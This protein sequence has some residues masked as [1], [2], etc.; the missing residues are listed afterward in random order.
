MKVRRTVLVMLPVLLAAGLMFPCTGRGL[1]YELNIDEDQHILVARLIINRLDLSAMVERPHYPDFFALVLAGVFAPFALGSVALGKV[2]GYPGIDAYRNFANL[3]LI[4]RITSAVFCMGSILILYKLA[5][6]VLDEGVAWTGAFLLA[7]AFPFVQYGVRGVNDACVTFLT[8][9]SVYL[10]IRYGRSG[11]ARTFMASAFVA[12]CA[13]GTKYHVVPLGAVLLMALVGRWKAAGADAH[14]NLKRFLNA[15]LLLPAVAGMGGAFLGLPQ[16]FL[17]PALFV[18]TLRGEAEF[19]G[20]G[21]AALKILSPNYAAD[22]IEQLWWAWPILAIL[23]LILLVI[24][25][26]RSLETWL[27]ACFPVLF[28]A[29]MSGFKYKSPRYV[30]PAMPFVC[31]FAA[32][33]ISMVVRILPKK[34]RIASAVVL[35]AAV[36]APSA[37]SCVM[38]VRFS[39]R[40]STRI[41]ATRW[42]ET[43]VPAGT[44]IATEDYCPFLRDVDADLTWFDKRYPR[45]SF[46][47]LPTDLT[48]EGQRI[49]A[50]VDRIEKPDPV[51]RILKAQP[52]YVITSSQYKDRFYHSLVISRFPLKTRQRRDYYEWL[53]RHGEPVRRFAVGYSGKGNDCCPEISILRVDWAQLGEDEISRVKSLP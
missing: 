2:F 29:F 33:A 43:N 24:L 38:L 27:V 17:H 36:A 32:Y 37:W 19:F 15:H 42:I 14:F 44:T 5:K 6:D 7:V 1:P 51:R 26:R 22:Y 11:R 47:L 23:G 35:A 12:G 45:P 10:A 30:L 8:L 25:R 18:K 21:S 40:T 50:I 13:V 16:M 31:L 46:R 48:P 52:D 28:I 4:A 3:M 39:L 20:T 53:Q 41:E 49:H 9:L 34:A